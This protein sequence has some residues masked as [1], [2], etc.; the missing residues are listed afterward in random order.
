MKKKILFILVSVL[1]VSV[2]AACNGKSEDG[3]VN[4]ENSADLSSLLQKGGASKYTYV[5]FGRPSCEYCQ[6]FK[7]KLESS[8]KKT[9]TQAL[10]YNTDEHRQDKDFTELMEKFDV[11]KIPYLVKIKDGAIVDSIF[12]VSKEQ[13]ITDFMNK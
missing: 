6:D 12:D 8:L 4:A 7:P 1:I 9:G 13:D 10:Y 3:L 2:L 5:Y 11:T